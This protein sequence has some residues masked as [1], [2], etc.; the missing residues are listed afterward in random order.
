ML[1]TG[2]LNRHLKEIDRQAEELFSQVV[3]SLARSEGA[4]ERLKA[5]DQMAWV[6]LMNSIRH[7]AEEIVRKELIEV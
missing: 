2:T 1:L 3:E 4:T 7:R 6:G 5:T